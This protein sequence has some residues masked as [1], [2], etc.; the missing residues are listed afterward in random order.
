MSYFVN[1]KL[2]INRYMPTI[3]ITISGTIEI[4]ISD[5]ISVIIKI[6]ISVIIIFSYFS[7]G[8]R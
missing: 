2:R 3:K 5:I 8:N 1:D 4:I 6:I 7:N